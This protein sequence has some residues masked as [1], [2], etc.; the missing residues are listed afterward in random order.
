MDTG[1]SEAKNYTH[2]KSLTDVLIIT[3]RPACV[4]G[5]VIKQRPFETCTQE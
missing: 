4:V 3:K 2:K 1:S 5:C